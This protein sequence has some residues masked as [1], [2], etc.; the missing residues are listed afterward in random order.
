MKID[1]SVRGG[2]YDMLPGLD[3]QSE[4]VARGR[5]ARASVRLL[6]PWDVMAHD[7]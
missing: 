7:L 3:G 4:S 2:D 5:V 1:A 6:A